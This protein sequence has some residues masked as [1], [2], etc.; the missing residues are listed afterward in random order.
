MIKP[1]PIDPSG[2]VA[3]I[4]KSGLTI[5]DPIKVGDPALWIPAPQLQQLLDRGLRGM[6]L[7]GLPLRTRSKAVKERICDVLGYPRPV[8]FQRTNPRFPGQ[9]FDT[10][11]HKADN[12]QVWNEQISPARR[13]VLVRVSETAVVTRVKVVT[14]DTLANLDTS[15]KLTQKYQ[16]RCMP[17]TA[18][19]ELITQTDTENLQPLVTTKFDLLKRAATPVGPPQAG[20]IL[21]IRTVFELL[22]SL[23][24]TKFADAGSDQERNRGALLHR[25]VCKQLG[26]AGYQD[27]GQFPDIR[28][29]LLE[30]KLQTS[31]TIDLGLVRPDS[32]APLDVPMI[33]GRQI[34]HCD[35]RYA[36]FYAGIS[37]QTISLTHFFLTTAQAFFTRFPQFQG[38]VF[39][40][41]LQI[42]LP[43]NFFDI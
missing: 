28:N 11:V 33:A 8:S 40:A 39:N 2:Y 30:I 18:T 6:P 19:R 17:R 13:Y 22:S 15:G 42:H 38:K 20:E 32:V 16:A 35:I 27:D 14:G 3:A 7:A 26:Y 25:L 1:N 23:I 41:K 9:S 24:G 5:Y 12:L 31:P 4:K 43:P 37:N 34:R 10:Y 29:Q 21:S 36:I